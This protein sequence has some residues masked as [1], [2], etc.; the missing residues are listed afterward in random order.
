EPFDSLCRIAVGHGRPASRDAAGESP[1][2]VRVLEAVLMQVWAEGRICATGDEQRM[3]RGVCVVRVTRQRG[4]ARVD[5][6]TQAAVLLHKSDTPSGGGE[7]S[8]GHQTVDPCPDHNDVICVHR[9]LH[10]FHVSTHL[11]IP[12]SCLVG[13]REVRTPWD[14]GTTPEGAHGRARSQ[15]DMSA[16]WNCCPIGRISAAHADRDVTMVGSETPWPNECMRYDML[17]LLCAD[18]PENNSQPNDALPRQSGKPEPWAPPGR[19]LLGLLA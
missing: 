3:P 15:R 18:R 12:T 11:R 2:G 8:R 13:Q 7:L 19:I 16:L 1:V 9:F 17:S 10:V 14:L 6:S 5:E 4:L